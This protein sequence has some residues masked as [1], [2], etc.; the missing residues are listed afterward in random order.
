MAALQPWANGRS[1]L[2]FAEKQIDVRTAYREQVWTQ[3]SG[4]RSAYDPHGRF[5]ANHKVPRLFE[6]GRAVS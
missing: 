6:Q 5:V 2:N 3:L 1:Y 4:I